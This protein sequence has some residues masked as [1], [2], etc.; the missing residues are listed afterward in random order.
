MPP[1]IA[2]L[3]AAPARPGLRTGLPADVEGLA[4]CESVSASIGSMPQGEVNYGR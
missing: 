3:A 4:H 1:S 2:F